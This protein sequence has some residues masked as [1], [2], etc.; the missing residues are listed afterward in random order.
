[1]FVWTAGL[2]MRILVL[3][4]YVYTLLWLMSLAHDHSVL[5]VRSPVM[6]TVPRIMS[7]LAHALNSHAVFSADLMFCDWNV[8][9]I[10]IFQLGSPQTAQ[11]ACIQ[12]RDGV[13]T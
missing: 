11:R 10:K 1:M 9:A 5:I 12:N 8:V 4:T 3:A 6:S 13:S 7:Q 2:R